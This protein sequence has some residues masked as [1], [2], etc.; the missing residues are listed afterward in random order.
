MHKPSP[1][2]LKLNTCMQC[3]WHAAKYDQCKRKIQL[4]SSA[5]PILVT[6]YMLLMMMLCE[7][8]LIIDADHALHAFKEAVHIHHFHSCIQSIIGS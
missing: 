4:A 2:A 1:L 6:F 3:D 7:H 8:E 5:A